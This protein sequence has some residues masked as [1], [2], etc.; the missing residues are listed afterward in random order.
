MFTPHAPKSG[1]RAVLLTNILHLLRRLK[2]M[3]DQWGQSAGA[4]LSLI[5]VASFRYLYLMLGGVCV[6]P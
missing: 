2:H 4:G 5:L 3:G 1:H 6:Q